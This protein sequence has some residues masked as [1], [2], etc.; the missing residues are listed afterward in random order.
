MNARPVALTLFSMSKILG[1][2]EAAE[3]RGEEDAAADDHLRQ[4]CLVR[5]GL[6]QS[7]AVAHNGKRAHV[8]RGHRRVA[9]RGLPELFLSDLRDPR[10]LLLTPVRHDSGQYTDRTS[11]FR[12][13]G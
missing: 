13:F 9:L 2:L 7:A 10:Q 4:P 8:L 6:H 11:A 12:P 1:H 5:S 3:V